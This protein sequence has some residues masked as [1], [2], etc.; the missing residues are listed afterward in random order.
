[1]KRFTFAGAPADSCGKPGGTEHGPDALRDVGMM[2]AMKTGHAG[3]LDTPMHGTRRDSA[4][5]LVALDGVIEATLVLRRRL[6]HMIEDGQMPFVAGGCNAILP[7]AIA[8][9]RDGLPS[10]Q[11]LGLIYVSGHMDLYD[12][13]TSPNG[14]GAD[15]AL[16]AAL[17]R[18]PRAWCALLGDQ[19]PVKS[20]AVA[21]VGFRDRE[22]AEQQDA[23]MPEDFQP[24]LCAYDLDRMRDEGPGAASRAALG[25]AAA[26]GARF[27]LHID[28]DVL[29][30]LA[31]PAADN[32]MPGGL[33]WDELSALLR[34][35]FTS[36]ALLGV[37]LSGYN[38]EKDEGSSC[39]L[40]LVDLFRALSE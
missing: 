21:L 3:D 28:V 8:G 25:R 11:T 24:H 40:H 20:E 35:M 37:T 2:A 12:G 31:F 16:A 18:G 29:D 38:P 26:P 10:N 4:S 14:Y 7:G 15:M 33:D 34:P 17:G 22:E 23:L 9:A 19:P 32:Q 5:G 36:S 13:D 39:G 30:E 1:M 6:A 27:W